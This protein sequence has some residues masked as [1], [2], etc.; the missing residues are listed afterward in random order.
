MYKNMKIALVGVGGMGSVHFNVY[1]NMPDIEFVACDVRIDMLREKVGDLPI[2]IYSDM[3]EMLEKENPDMVD[4]CTPT[5]LHAEQAIKAMRSGAHV[6]SEKPMGLNSAECKRILA[7][8]KET[9]KRYMVAQVVRFMAPFVYLRRVIESGKY[10]KLESLTMQRYSQIP[11]WSWENWMLDSKKSGQVAIDL[12]IHDIDFMQYVLGEPN[13][14]TG[15]YRELDDSLTNY[16]FINYIYDGFAVSIESG[17]Y[18][19][20]KTRFQSTFKA[21][22]E[23][24]NIILDSHGNLY[25][26]NDAVDLSNVEQLEKTEVNIN[27]VNGYA[28][29]IQYFIDCINS[30][31]P[32][33]LAL[34]ESSARSVALVERTLDNVIKL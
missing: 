13:E 11:M 4:I 15:V 18:K 10:G 32:N 12:M 22:F 21:V 1:K 16:G 31:K 24:G 17:W 8:V 33:D 28:A 20:Q 19:D 23:N 6:L 29:E 27:N 3:D 9:G 7:V 34:G 25:D 26:C 2:R 30:G 5:Y 14:I